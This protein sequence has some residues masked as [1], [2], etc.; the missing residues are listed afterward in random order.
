MAGLKNHGCE[1]HEHHWENI[2]RIL[3]VDRPM[4]TGSFGLLLAGYIVICFALCALQC[5]FPSR[6][7]ISFGAGAILHFRACC[8]YGDSG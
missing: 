2:P 8:R 6:E 7:Q 5:G 1:L 3:H 4:A